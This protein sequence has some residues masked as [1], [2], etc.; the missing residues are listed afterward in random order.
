MFIG[1]HLK[2]GSYLHAKGVERG[3]LHKRDVAQNEERHLSRRDF[4]GETK[5]AQ[6]VLGLALRQLVVVVRKL[7]VTPT[8]GKVS[9]EGKVV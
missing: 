3:T 5:L 8:C 9:M 6:C 2:G 1:G 7:Q 4:G